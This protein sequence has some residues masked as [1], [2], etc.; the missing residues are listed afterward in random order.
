SM[1]TPLYFLFSAAVGL[2]LHASALAQIS[3]SSSDVLGDYVSGKSL[4][5]YSSSDTVVM[6]I[7][8]ASSSSAQTWTA[9]S[10]K[11]NDSLRLDGIAPS[12]TPYSA[13]F[14]GATYAQAAS[15]TEGPLSVSFY[16]YY[17][18]SNDSLI[19]LGSVQHLKGSSGGVTLDSTAFKTSPQAVFVFPLQLGKSITHQTDTI[20]SQ[21]ADVETETETDNFDAYGTLTLPN[22][23]FPALRETGTNVTKIYVSG[24]LANTVTSYTITWLT[25][26][27]NQLEVQLDT[28]STGSVRV[29]SISMFYFG[30]TPA[31]AVKSSDQLPGSFALSQNYPNPFNP[32]TEIGFQIP[33]NSRVS[34]KVYDALGREVATL[35]DADRPAGSYSVTFNG[36]GLPSGVYFYR[37]QAGEHSMTKKLVLVK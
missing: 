37:I 22:G 2:F 3:I 14:P 9:P 8:S 13:S 20:Y 35:V 25:E 34:L 19:A 26:S 24:S 11:I 18:L 6:N 23:S 31:T 28:L 4:F 21:G 7:G 16:A 15:L 30:A 27:G 36:A 33:K 17:K 29:H 10:V 32:T 12:S 5:G 1:K